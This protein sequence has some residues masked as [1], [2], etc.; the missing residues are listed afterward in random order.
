[1]NNMVLVFL[2]AC[3]GLAVAITGA[4]L[5]QFGAFGLRQTPITSVRG[6]GILMLCLGAGLVMRK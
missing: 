2:M 4:L 5:D 6:I 1:M 3:G